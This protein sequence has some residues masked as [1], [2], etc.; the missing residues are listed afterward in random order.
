[1]SAIKMSSPADNAVAQVLMLA[2]QQHQA[3]RLPDAEAGYRQVLTADPNNATAMYGL[4]TVALQVGEIDIAVD[5]IRRA[6]ELNGEWAEACYRL[7]RAYQARGELDA[8]IIALRKA[9]ALSPVLFEAQYNL[10]VCLQVEGEID[11]AITAYEAALALKPNDAAALFQ[12]SVA[13]HGAG[14]RDD[15]I[16]ALR[17]T[18]AVKPDHPDAYCNLGAELWDK[19]LFEEALAEFRRAVELAPQNPSANINLTNA[20]WQTG[21]IGEAIAVQRRVVAFRPDDADAHRTLGVL[22]LLSGDY[23][24]GLGHFEW[25]WRVKKNFPWPRRKFSQPM[26]DGGDLAGRT[27]YLH[28]EQSAGDSIQFIRFLPMVLQRGGRIIVECQRSLHRLFQGKWDVAQW[29]SPGEE[30]PAFDVYCPLLSLPFVL[31]ITPQSLPAEMPYLRADPDESQMWREKLSETGP[32]KVGL[33]WAGSASEP[34]DRKRSISLSQFSPLGDIPGVRY[35]SLQTGWA[36]GQM[37]DQNA[38]MKIT[39]L[40]GELTDFAVTAAVIHSLDLVITVDTAV[41]HLAGAMGRPVWTLLP[42]V[43]NW[44]WTATGEA[45][46]WYPS[47]RLLRQTKLGNWGEV[48]SRVTGELRHL[49]S[50]SGAS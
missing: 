10:A 19:G 1:L 3:G 35:F 8:A 22:L 39:D 21:R 34:Q 23:E 43:P 42:Y 18:I 38:E 31:E 5:L 30:M 12:L 25:R 4:G 33:V 9:V 11:K 26:W 14:R 49:R 29:L 50:N 47:M 28:T 36:A 24:E 6:I 20:L 48:I 16:T 32:M 13:L 41:A 45:T 27:I 15:S 17:K 40:G 2:M 46:P 7:G 44:R 37:Q